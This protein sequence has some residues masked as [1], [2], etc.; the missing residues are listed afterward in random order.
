[1]DASKFQQ[2]SR[3]RNPSTSTGPEPSTLTLG[4]T[5]PHSRKFTSREY[6]DDRFLTAPK[7]VLTFALDSGGYLLAGGMQAGIQG[8]FHIHSKTQLM[9]QIV[10]HSR[11]PAMVTLTTSVK[12]VEVAPT[13]DENR[14]LRIGID[15]NDS[16]LGTGMPHENQRELLRRRS[17]LA[18]DEVASK[19]R[20]DWI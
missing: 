9:L 7:T 2:A 6:P 19:G 3:P 16:A 18:I 14:A 4:Q 5:S 15:R 10:D 8:G 20:L 1:M 13:H 11:A 17:S 12:C